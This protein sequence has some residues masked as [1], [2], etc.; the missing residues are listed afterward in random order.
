VKFLRVDEMLLELGSHPAA[1][2]TAAALD[3]E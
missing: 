2:V 3:A 1:G